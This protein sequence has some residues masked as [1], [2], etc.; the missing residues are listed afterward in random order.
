MCLR[1]I[2]SELKTKEEQKETLLAPDLNTDDVGRQES[3]PAGD[4]KQLNSEIRQVLW[5]LS[6]EGAW[7]SRQRVQI[8]NNRITFYKLEVL[9]N[10]IEKS[11]EDIKK[12]TVKTVKHHEDNKRDMK[13]LLYRTIPLKVVFCSLISHVS[14]LLMTRD[15]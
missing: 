11:I 13:F 14:H 9:R 8:A 3:L 4:L 15:V 2:Y 5:H 10:D 12:E 1:S 7:N 6:V